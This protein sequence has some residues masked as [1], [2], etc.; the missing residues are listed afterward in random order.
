MIV[1]WMNNRFNVKCFAWALSICCSGTLLSNF[2]SY[3]GPKVEF[4][5][6]WSRTNSWLRHSGP[7]VDSLTTIVGGC[8]HGAVD[9][10][11]TDCRFGLPGHPKA[12]GGLQ[13]GGAGVPVQRVPQP[14][15]TR[16]IP[17]VDNTHPEGQDQIQSYTDQ[18]ETCRRC[19]LT[20]TSD[21]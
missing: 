2:R 17:E 4:A 13:V 21:C 11:M 7:A 19:L 8:S 20:S 18:E 12:A 15:I 14:H 1:V 6:H 9:L 16:R 10:D 3:C 5:F